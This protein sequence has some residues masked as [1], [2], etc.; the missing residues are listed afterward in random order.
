M[1]EIDNF[2]ITDVSWLLSGLRTDIFISIM[3]KEN[4]C[5]DLIEIREICT[6]I[7]GPPLV[8]PPFQGILT[9]YTDH[10]VETTPWY[11]ERKSVRK[12]TD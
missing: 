7:L 4:V 11:S 9:S 10:E 8:Q 3:S 2:K 12:W 5:K 1:G 6:N